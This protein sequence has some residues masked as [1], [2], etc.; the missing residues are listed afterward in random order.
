MFLLNVQSL[1]NKVD[2]LFIVL[3]GLDFPDMLCITEH[4]LKFDEIV[5]V[6]NYNVVSKFCRSSSPHGGTM[7]L[8][9]ERN[10]NNFSFLSVNK[11]DYLTVEKVFECSVVFCSTYR[12]Y[13]M[14]LYRSPSGDLTTFL[15]NLETLLSDLPVN[16]SV[17]LTGDL[18]LDFN[19]NSSECVCNLLSCFNLKMHV[20]EPTRVTK[21]TSST[22]DYM[23]SN[24]SCISCSVVNAALSDHE[25]VVSKYELNLKQTERVVRKG[26]LYCKGNFRRFRGLCNGAEWNFSQ[27][28]DPLREF[29][30]VLTNIFNR[31]FP[32][33]KIKPKS[34]K[35]WLTRAIKVSAG[36]MRALHYIRKFFIDDRFFVSYF[37]KYRS[38]YRRVVRS[39]KRLYYGQR[40]RKSKNRS[41]ETWLIVNN[42]RQTKNGNDKGM[43]YQP[44]PSELND[45]YC[46]IGA[47]LSSR[48]TPSI[49]PLTYLA[50]SH[51][52][53]TFYMYPTDIEELKCIFSE[54]KNKNASGWDDMSIKIFGEMSEC[55]LN[56]LVEAVN[57]S[58]I[59][60][61]FP[62]F[63]KKAI[64]VPLHKGGNEYTPSNFR[65]ISLLPTLSK[66]IEKLVKNRVTSFLLRNNVLNPNQ[67]GFQTNKSTNDALFSFLEKLYVGLNNGDIAGAVFCDL[68]KAFD[69]VSHSILFQKLEVYG[70]RGVTLKWFRSYLT[71]R[72]Q[73]VSVGGKMSGFQNVECGVP[74]GS[75]LGPI[76]FLLYI[77]DITNVD[78]S[79]AFTLFADDTTILWRD[80][81]SVSLYNKVQGDLQE[82]RK[83]F[84]CNLLTFNLTKTNILTFKC[85]LQEVHLDAISLNPVN[86]VKFLG[87]H[88]D[89]LLN[90]SS[91]IKGLLKKLSSGCY[92]LRIIAKD[93]EPQ[94]VKIS[95]YALIESH[96]R[97]GIAFWGVCSD[98]LFNSVFVLQKR[99]LRFMYGIARRESCRPYFLREGIM[100]L[101]CIF[102][103][104]S[105]CLVF[106]KYRSLISV[107]HYGTRQTGN[108]PLPIPHSSQVKKSFIYNAKKM[109]NHLPN[110]F[111]DIN[112]LKKFKTEITKFLSG[113]AYYN[114][115][116]YFCDEF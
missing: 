78:I 22:L 109:Y 88:V 102:M 40:I 31:A 25:A 29:H 19:G 79:G 42:I 98:Y 10:N 82:L 70:F 87:M 14:C 108:V 39:A 32:I 81:N 107:G 55:A 72:T 100:T 67:F 2:E 52:S 62:D 1:K 85:E 44:D 68:T 76:L 30:L 51:V 75:V 15:N 97:Y 71:Q 12:I 45:F 80:S 41:K 56:S 74:Q 92:A 46:T 83:W 6:D 3:E 4:W 23:C 106:K 50:G 35:P 9:N 54:I 58:F 95:Y 37:S 63:L 96:L 20:T 115:T 27:C 26:R 105:M 5:K 34:K 59:N 99:A 61:Q 89:S 48:I 16:C 91:H 24:I 111:K 116:E 65:P 101:P 112:S 114:V 8:V 103:A 64:I 53:A 18:N 33:V 13:V 47:N 94:A 17:V 43:L 66:I 93:L 7:I 69:C 11:F 21:Y 90:F 36:N 49:S 28:D 77:N 57:H 86:N 38:V 60:G 104:E 84:D 73:S 110:S 113:R